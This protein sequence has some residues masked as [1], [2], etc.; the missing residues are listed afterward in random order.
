MNDSTGR[1]PSRK[2]ILA[3]P[4]A[5]LIA[6]IYAQQHGFAT[7]L[8]DARP[9]ELVAII[10]HDSTVLAEALRVRGWVNDDVI[11]PARNDR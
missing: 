11:T 4:L 1:T 3:D 7:G 9:Q 8:T 6:H 10:V 2:Q 5:D